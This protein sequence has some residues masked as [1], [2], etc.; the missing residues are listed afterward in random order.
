MWDFILT[1]WSFGAVITKLVWLAQ[2]AMIFHVFRTGRPYWWLLVLLFAPALGGLIYFFVEVLPGWRWEDPTGGW[3]P[4][5]MR[6]HEARAKVEETGTVQ[7]RLEL[8]GLLLAGGDTGGARQEAEA[9]MQGVF[10]DDPMVLA[11]V[12][13]YR[14]EAADQAAALEALDRANPHGDHQLALKLALLRGRALVLA[15][16]YDEAQEWLA[17][18][19]VGNLGDEPR[20]FRA[21]AL[22]LA[23]RTAEAREVWEEMRRHFRRA[24][25]AWARTERKW[26]ELA[27][28]RLSETRDR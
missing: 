12:A 1:N 20:Y 4:R 15:G 13:R 18:A 24:G 28:K 10:R 21:L 5:A 25:R 23:G 19:E 22:H 14:I 9:C 26:F 2:L 8:A 11:E 6:V 7:S 17:K 16:R 27:T 3:R